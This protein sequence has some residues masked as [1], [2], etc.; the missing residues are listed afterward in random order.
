MGRQSGGKEANTTLLVQTF[1][2]KERKRA[3]DMTSLACGPRGA[4]ASQ[5]GAEKVF[6]AEGR[7]EG[8]S[9]SLAWVLS[10]L[11]E[12][13]A[14]TNSYFSE[15]LNAEK[16]SQANANGMLIKTLSAVHSLTLLHTAENEEAEEEDEDSEDEDGSEAQPT[17]KED[18]RKQ[19]KRTKRAD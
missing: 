16:A 9:S 11:R 2:E 4:Y 5:E 12:I 14:Q 7:T 17:T 15:L 6:L 8:E 10:Q 1:S 18:L 19:D 3:A 13:R